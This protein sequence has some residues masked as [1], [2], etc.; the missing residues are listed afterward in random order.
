MDWTYGLSGVDY[1]VDTFSKSYKTI[2]KE[3][4]CQVCIRYDN[5]NSFKVRFALQ[6]WERGKDPA[7]SEPPTGHRKRTS[8]LFLKKK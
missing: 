6:V 2:E 4:L 7:G 8:L 5:S 1:K 3:S